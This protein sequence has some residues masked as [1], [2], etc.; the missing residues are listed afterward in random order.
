MMKNK[1]M[2]LGLLTGLLTSCGKRITDSVTPY[3]ISEEGTAFLEEMQGQWVGECTVLG[4]NFEWFTFDYRAIDESHTFGIYEGGSMGNLFTSFFIANYKGTRT[5]MARNGGVLNGIYRT[6]YFVLDKVDERASKTTY[7]FVDAVGGSKTM[8]MELAFSD[9]DLRWKAYTSGLGSSNRPYIHFEFN[10]TRG[11]QTEAQDIA[12]VLGYPKDVITWDFTAGLSESDMYV[13][14]GESA[15]KSAT[16]MAHDATKDVYQLAVDA[17]DPMTIMDYPEVA[18]LEINIENT[19]ATAN[20]KKQVYLSTEPLTTS[21]GMLL[22]EPFESVRH[23]PELA[24]L[25]TSFTMTY[26]HPGTY[27]VTV[28]ADLDEDMMPSTG[29]LNSKSE[30]I[31]IESATNNTITVN[32]I[33]YEI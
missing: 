26:L 3:E 17:L 29:D 28:I 31:I 9:N 18:T 15:P 2:L 10:A 1:L 7:R 24:A 23:F 30:M 13:L 32:N 33:T 4:M 6:S 21:T 12:Q 8:Y 20:A 25:D 11:E 16:Y 27:Y 5:L 22:T 19:T 14:P